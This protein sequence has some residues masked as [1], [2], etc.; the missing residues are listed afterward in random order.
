MND[1]PITAHPDDPQTGPD[2]LNSPLV[3]VTQGQ[4][5]TTV[6]PTKTPHR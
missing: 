5:V 2:G 4:E 3:E 6:R 1:M